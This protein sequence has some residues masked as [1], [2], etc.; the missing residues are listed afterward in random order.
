MKRTS[1]K[2][3]AQLWG[4]EA[5]LLESLRNRGR[6]TVEYVA[7]E[8]EQI[9]LRDERDLAALALDRD[10][11]LL[12]E[13]RAAQTRIANG[14]FGSCEECEREIPLKRLNAVPWARRC[15]QCQEKEDR[16][17]ACTFRQFSMAA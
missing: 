16:A 1:S 17:S 8:T 5:E 15:V 9:T 6:I 13:V 12:R 2:Y 11:K 14:T 7:E 4:K 3:D 10:S